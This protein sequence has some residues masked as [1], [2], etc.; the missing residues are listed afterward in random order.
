MFRDKK[1]QQAIGNIIQQTIDKTLSKQG[2]LPSAPVDDGRGRD[3]G[4]KDKIGGGGGGMPFKLP[5]IPLWVILVIVL[6]VIPTIICC[7]CIYCCCCRNKDGGVRRQGPSDEDPEAQR[8]GGGGIGNTL[9][10]MLSG[11]GGG[12]VMNMIQNCLRNRGQRQPAA[13][14]NRGGYVPPRPQA[15]EGKGLYPSKPVEDEGAG[16]GW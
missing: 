10:G 8:Q 5:N 13:G 9:R 4:R 2:Q 7:C 15:E 14:D 12:M 6:V 1:Y 3:A 11:A 16:G